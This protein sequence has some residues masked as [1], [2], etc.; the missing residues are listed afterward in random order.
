MNGRWPADWLFTLIQDGVYPDTGDLS[1][2]Y[3]E[4]AAEE[5]RRRRRRKLRLRKLR[6]LRKN[7]R[8]RL[9]QKTV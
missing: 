3:E 4:S 5:E 8:L 9:R 1:S 7:R 2:F 6:K